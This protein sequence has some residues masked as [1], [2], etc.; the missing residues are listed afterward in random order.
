MLLEELL[1]GRPERTGLSVT[2]G[3]A[4]HADLAERHALAGQQLLGANAVR[5]PGAG[6][7]EDLGHV[8]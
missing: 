3:L 1:R 5:A 8:T 2:Y 7:E 6:V 4:V